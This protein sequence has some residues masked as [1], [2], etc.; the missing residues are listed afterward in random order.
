MRLLLLALLTT[1]ATAAPPLDLTVHDS[2]RQRDVPVRIYL[3]EG[4]GPAPVILFSH[5][6][7]GARTNNPYLGKHW[8]QAG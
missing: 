2:A 8:S 3:P 7:G 5:G 6:L 4:K 1:L